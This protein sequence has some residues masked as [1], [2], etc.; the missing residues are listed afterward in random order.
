MAEF[1]VAAVAEFGV[2]AVAESGVGTCADGG[3]SIAAGRTDELANSH[4]YIHHRR[5][6]E[7][8]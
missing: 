4:L 1:S 7:I 6:V 8:G 2:A 3:K 5:L